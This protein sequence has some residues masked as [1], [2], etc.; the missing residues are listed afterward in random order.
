MKPTQGRSRVMVGVP[1]LTLWINETDTCV[2]T[3][4]TFVLDV[5]IYYESAIKPT[6]DDPGCAE[7]VELLDAYLLTPLH[8]SNEDG[9][10]VAL[11][12]K[13][14][15]INLLREHQYNAI[16]DCV[17]RETEDALN[18]TEEL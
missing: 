4:H 9:V 7:Y 11:S 10:S 1:K 18:Y 15:L 6:E 12:H 3:S 5:G 14:N 17:K 13:L 16:I 2:E 8:L